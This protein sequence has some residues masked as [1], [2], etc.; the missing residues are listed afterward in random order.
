MIGLMLDKRGQNQ[1]GKEF[2]NILNVVNIIGRIAKQLYLSSSL[3]SHNGQ[4]K[5]LVFQNIAAGVQK[6]KKADGVSVN[7]IRCYLDD[8][9]G[10]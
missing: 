1:R 6:C 9:D 10:H 4:G 3:R 8:C 5:G 7:I 2:S